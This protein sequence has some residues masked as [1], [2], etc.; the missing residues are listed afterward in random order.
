M[1]CTSVGVPVGVVDGILLVVDGILL[2]GGGLPL[3]V[4][5]TL[6]MAGG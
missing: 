5:D 3:M 6:L 2:E 4:D 1:K